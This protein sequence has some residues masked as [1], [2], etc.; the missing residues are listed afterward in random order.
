MKKKVFSLLMTIL[1]IVMPL[2]SGT[3]ALAQEQMSEAVKCVIPFKAAV[4]VGPS[5]G[6]A[7]EGN[8]M[9]E[10]DGAGDLQGQLEMESG[11]PIPVF[12]Q[13]VGRAI[14]LIFELEPTTESAVGSYIF[15]TGTTRN[16]IQTDPLCGTAL[17]GTFAGP[18]EGDTGDWAGFCV[19]LRDFTSPT[20]FTTICELQ[21]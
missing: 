9:I 21:G 2:Y 7:L 16:P 10:V 1:V 3:L 15:G 11:E 19:K 4:N 6:T 18:E 12:G 8:L 14:S 17:G 20:G 5:S 13:V